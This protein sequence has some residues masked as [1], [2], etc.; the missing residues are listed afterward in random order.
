MAPDTITIPRLELLGVLI[1]IL[2]LKVVLNELHLQVTYKMLYT[3]S[4]CVL[5]WL[6]TEKSLLPFITNRLNE[7]KM[8]KD[9]IFKN[10]P[11][12][13]NSADLATRGKPPNEH[14]LVA[15]DN[16]MHNTRRHQ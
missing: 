14:E 15:G 5:H 12:E 3:D 4:L 13:E 10:V 6:Q 2:A 1:G 16:S 9:V 11:T 8:L 7:I